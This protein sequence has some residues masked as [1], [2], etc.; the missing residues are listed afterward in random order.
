MKLK[1]I[2]IFLILLCFHCGILGAQ[3]NF[4]LKGNS[5]DKI[6]FELVSNLIIIPIEVNDVP[7]S[8][9]L[10]T[11]VSKPILFNL[12]EDDSLN[13]QSIQKFSLHGLGADG[14]IEAIRS[15][16]NRI[17]FGN[18]LGTNQDLFV[19]FDQSIDFTPRLGIWIHGIIGYDLFKD[20]IVEINYSGKYIRLHKHESFKNKASKKWRRIPLDVYRNKPYVNSFATI[21]EDEKP[22]KLLID[23]G[24]SDALWLFENKNKGLYPNLNKNFVDYLGKGLSGSVYGKRSKIN[25]F[26]LSDF[27]LNNVNVAFPDSVSIDKNRI[28]KDR[29]GSLG[30]EILKRFNLFFDYKNEMLYLKKNSNYK[31]SFTYNNSGIVLERNGSQFIREKVKVP[32][33]DNFSQSDMNAVRINM[34]IDY[35]VVL[36]PIY[37]VVEL[38]ETSNAYASGLRI[39]DIIIAVNGHEVYEYKLPEVNSFFHG[40]PGKVVRL[41]IERYGKTMTIKF[42]LDDVFKITKPSKN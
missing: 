24:S 29:N 34:S 27:E 35:R 8:F 37:E 28:Y 7:L 40:N 31:L 13:L 14:E 41:K 26:K 42:K 17:K 5:S 18:A 3:G 11:G 23:T 6:K 12:T 2:H 32:S 9:V 20:F 21:G 22:I 15:K 4:F 36:K 38:R 25:T 39:G 19:V 33:K 30:G 1:S 10:D 16:Y